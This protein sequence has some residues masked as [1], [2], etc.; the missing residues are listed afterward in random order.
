[1]KRHPAPWRSR[2]C[3][4]SQT[5]K[6]PCLWALVSGLED[7]LEDFAP[8]GEDLLNVGSYQVPLYQSPARNSIANVI[9]YDGSAALC[10]EGVLMDP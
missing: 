5:Q 3:T 4:F 8:E 1:M 7:C 6:L 2:L 10:L 9:P